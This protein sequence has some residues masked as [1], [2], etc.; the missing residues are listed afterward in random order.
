MSVVKFPGKDHHNAI[1]KT[2]DCKYQY[3]LI[4]NIK[5]KKYGAQIARYFGDEVEIIYT[6]RQFNTAKEAEAVAKGFIECLHYVEQR[7]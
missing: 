5:S 4:R 3:R 1:H 6:I 7:Q 2:C